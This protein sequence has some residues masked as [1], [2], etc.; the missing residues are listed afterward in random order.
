M[1]EALTAT[2][3]DTRRSRGSLLVVLQFGDESHRSRCCVDDERLS[4]DAFRLSCP[5]LAEFE[6]ALIQER[7]RAGL[8]NRALRV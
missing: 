1:I 4:P 5:R 6:R 2:A 7:V 3:R 8:R